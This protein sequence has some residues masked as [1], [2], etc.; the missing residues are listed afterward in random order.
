M[1]VAGRPPSLAVVAIV[2]LTLA[3]CDP[4]GESSASSSAPSTG[5][6][7][8]TTPA[9]PDA[10][11]VYSPSPTP[12]TEKTTGYL[13]ETLTLPTGDGGKLYVTYES[14]SMTTEFVDDR[15]SLAVWLKVENPGDKDWT[16]DLGADAEVADE[17]GLSFRAVPRPASEDVHPHPERYGYSNRNL[18]RT[19]TVGAGDSVQGVIVFRPSGG[20]RDIT[21]E[22]SLDGGTTVA[23]W[24]TAMGPF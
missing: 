17:T 13:G 16:G 23:S 22:L 12:F 4:S 20:N 9:G 14:T 1:T 8:A 5:P 24:Q 3:G 6:G 2:A 21:I 18:A 11:P 15:R 7:T 10:L 19:T